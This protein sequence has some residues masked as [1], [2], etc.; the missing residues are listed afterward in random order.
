MA[1]TPINLAPIPMESP[2]NQIPVMI[3]NEPKK[4]VKILAHIFLL[5]NENAIEIG[6]NK[7]I[8]R[9]IRLTTSAKDSIQVVLQ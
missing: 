9:R 8:D 3:D 7:S 1:K 6:P 2:A 4:K 5:A